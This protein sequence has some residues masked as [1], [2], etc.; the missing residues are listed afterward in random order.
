MLR[1]HF[2]VQYRHKTAAR[3]FET[4]KRNCLTFAFQESAMYINLGIP[5]VLRVDG[6]YGMTATINDDWAGIGKEENVIL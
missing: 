6:L 5:N 1:I 3:T 2:T 4:A